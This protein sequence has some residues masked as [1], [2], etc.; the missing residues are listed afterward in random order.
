[1]SYL[2]TKQALITKL[3]S[4]NITGITVDD[5]AFENKNFDP[6]NKSK[7][8]SCYF[9]PASTESTGKTLASGDEQRGI[10]QVSVY[11]Q[12]NSDDYD[13]TQLEII[14]AILSEFQYSTNTVYNNQ[15]VDILES[16]VNAGFENESWFKR[17]ISINYL[18]FSI[19]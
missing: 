6:K 14:D 17:D 13:N 11:V 12:L 5:I 9:I 15:H 19:R 18:T 2:N 7:W 1:M 3:L 16:T 8:I 10:F 4:A